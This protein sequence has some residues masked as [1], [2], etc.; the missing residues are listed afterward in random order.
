VGACMAKGL[1][2]AKIAWKVE[3]EI[4]AFL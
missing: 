4:A 3:N 1:S 2:N